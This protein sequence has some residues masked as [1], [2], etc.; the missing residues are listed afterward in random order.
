MSAQN[1]NQSVGGVENVNA[2][3]P[4]LRSILAASLAQPSMVG[5]VQLSPSGSEPAPRLHPKMAKREP[6]RVSLSQL[7]LAQAGRAATENQK[8]F[9]SQ[10]RGLNP[11]SVLRYR[12]HH[13]RCLRV[14]LEREELGQQREQR[15]DPVETRRRQEGQGRGLPKEQTCPCRGVEGLARHGRQVS[16]RKGTKMDK[17]EAASFS[18]SIYQPSSPPSGRL[19]PMKLLPKDQDKLL[20]HQVS[21]LTICSLSIIIC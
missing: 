1:V 18:L 2:E 4:Y 11:R 12:R 19:H 10:T 8:P 5:M 20:L 21:H 7:Q 6:G 3:R 16:K 9:R 17:S 14:R 15:K 13:Y